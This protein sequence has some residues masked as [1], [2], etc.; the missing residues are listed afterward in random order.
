MLRI[1]LATLVV[2]P[3]KRLPAK[4]ALQIKTKLQLLAADPEPPDSLQMKDKAAKFRR[5]DSGEY[6]IIYRVEENALKVA[7]VG[8]RND[9]KVYRDFERKL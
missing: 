7:T 1:E 9:D 2:K 4:H 6:R 3:I 5:A 8:N